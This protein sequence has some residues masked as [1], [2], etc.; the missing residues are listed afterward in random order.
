[1]N[2][3][4]MTSSPSVLASAT[5]PISR[6]NGAAHADL[7]G[8]VLQAHE[9]R[10]A[11]G[12]E[13][14]TP[15]DGQAD[16]RRRARTASRAGSASR[17]CCVA[18]RLKNSDSRMIAPKSAIDAGGDD[19]L[20]ERRGDLAGVLEHRDQRRRATWRTAATATKHRRRR[21]GRAPSGRA[22]TASA[23]AND[24][25][26]PTQRDAQ[27]R[28][29]AGGRTRSPGRRGTAGSPGRR[30]PGPRPARRPRPSRAPP[31]RS[32]SRA[33][34]RARPPAAA[35]AGRSRAR[36]ARRTRPRPTIEQVG[37][38]E[39]HGVHGVQTS[40]PAR[41][42]RA[43]CNGRRGNRTGELPASRSTHPPLARSSP[44]NEG[45]LDMRA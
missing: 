25:T 36:A 16:Q 15:G 13:R 1:M 14:S 29:R 34:A 31:G 44:P 32:R 4:R 19:E 33:A 35:A 20:A 18:S 12:V 42:L 11:A 10:R 39:A 23:S 45:G 43:A 22:P 30:A 24:S 37:E 3:P 8:R 27:R 21:R 9:R 41:A 2:A 17:S 7:R 28:A 40:R 26:K 38:L 5:K 6:T